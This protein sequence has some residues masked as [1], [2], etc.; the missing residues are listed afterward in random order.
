MEP[1]LTSL[2]NWQFILFGLAIFAIM[3]V[4]RILIEY[5][6]EL[7]KSDPKKSILWNEVLLPILPV[8]TGAIVATYLKAFPYPNGLTTRGDR[9]IFG[10]VAG[11]LSGLIYRVIKS[12]LYQN[13]ANIV[14]NAETTVKQIAPTTVKAE[15]VLVITEKT[16]DNK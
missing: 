7:V 11:L 9:I 15:Q 5:F 3:Y 13:V 2:F 14:Q 6:M 8:F 12:L 1:A 4:F 16:L 10:L